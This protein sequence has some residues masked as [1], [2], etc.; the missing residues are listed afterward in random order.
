MLIA[1]KSATLRGVLGYPVTVELH[2]S[3]GI[4]G[5]SVVGLRAG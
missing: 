4:G 2:I 1:I 5:F 3:P